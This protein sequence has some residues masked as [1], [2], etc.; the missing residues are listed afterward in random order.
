VRKPRAVTDLKTIVFVIFLTAGPWKGD[1]RF[2]WIPFDL[3]LLAAIATVVLVGVEI[4]RMREHVPRGAGWLLA[5]WWLLAIPIAW[6]DMTPYA[7]VKVTRLFSLT[8][9]VSVAPLFLFRTREEVRRFLFTYGCVGFVMA[10][11]V[12]RQVLQGQS[13]QALTAFAADTITVGRSMGMTFIWIFFLVLNRRL[14]PVRGIPLLALVG[15]TALA[16]GSKG[17]LLFGLSSIALSVLL[18]YRQKLKRLAKLG[19]LAMFL[20]LQLSQLVEYVPQGALRRLTRFLSG[21]FSSDSIVDR[22]QLF[23]EAMRSIPNHPLGTGWGVYEVRIGT[24]TNIYPHNLVLEIL[25]EAGWV[26]GAFFVYLLILAGY[27]AYKNATNTE[28]MIVFTL[29]T[30]AVGNSMV[31]GDMNG[32]RLF[33]ALFG[34][35]LQR[36]YDLARAP[37]PR[38]VGPSPPGF[39]GVRPPKGSRLL[40]PPPRTDGEVHLPTR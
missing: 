17:P 38:T 23:E 29:Y 35:S 33:W 20:L 21:D 15:F 7:M 27:R 11:D 12:L 31:S 2:A 40:P 19:L 10:A 37:A 13:Q 6:T 18:F 8:V 24:M 1:P 22:R 5:F 3:T 25:Y 39:P 16:S 30:F 26:A 34:L 4:L 14:S 9:L 28:W 36:M 32:E